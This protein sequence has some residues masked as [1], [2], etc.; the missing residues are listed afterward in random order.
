MRLQRTVKAVIQSGEDSGYVAECF[1]INVVTQ[2]N[3]LDEVSANLS[4][5]VKLFFDGESLSELGFA[6]DPTIIVTYE[7]EP[8]YA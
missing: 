5:A 3:T 6:D 4:E 1:E 8:I 2:G 7:L